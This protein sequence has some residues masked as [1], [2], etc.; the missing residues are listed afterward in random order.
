MVYQ[1]TIWLKNKEKLL[2][3]LEK[4]SNIERLKLRTGNIEMVDHYPF[5]AAMI[6][7]K[8]LKFAKELN[9]KNF[10][11]LDGWLRWKEWNYTTFKPVWGESK[12]ATREMVD[13]WWETS[14][15]T[16]LSNYELT[17][18]HSTDEFGLFYECLPNKVHLPKCSG[19]TIYNLVLEINIQHPMP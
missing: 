11:A 16:L 8:D 19:R 4:G 13:G 2:N 12:S 15:P 17:D 10:L 14:L 9:V 3:L 18:V 7:E 5:S 6:Q 1:K